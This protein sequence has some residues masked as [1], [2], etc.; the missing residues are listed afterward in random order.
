MSAVPMSNT[1]YYSSVSRG[2]IMCAYCGATINTRTRKEIGLFTHLAAFGICLTG[3][4]P[5]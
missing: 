4:I 2:P 5:W 1:G 3:C